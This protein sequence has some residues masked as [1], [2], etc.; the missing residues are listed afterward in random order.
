MEEVAARYI[1]EIK[2]AQP[3]SPYS[4]GGA[5]FGGVIAFEIA[6]QLRSRGEP[7]RVRRRQEELP[8]VWPSARPQ[9]T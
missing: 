2:T 7:L 3:R 6:Q 8:R 9:L 4:L 1:A 5:C